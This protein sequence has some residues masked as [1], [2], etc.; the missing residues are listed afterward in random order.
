M[1]IRHRVLIRYD[2]LEDFD[3]VMTLVEGGEDVQSKHV[4]FSGLRHRE[5]GAV[6][7][8]L[9]AAAGVRRKQRNATA[10]H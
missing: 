4:N 2:E 9:I 10:Q 3:G 6:L 7:H 1:K 8:S 5:L